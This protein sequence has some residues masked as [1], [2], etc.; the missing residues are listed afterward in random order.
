MGDSTTLRVK[1]QLM[2]ALQ[3]SLPDGAIRTLGQIGIETDH[4]TGQLKINEDALSQALEQ[5]THGVSRLLAGE[6]GL[7]AQVTQAIDPFQIGRAS[8]RG[9]GDASA[10]SRGGRATAQRR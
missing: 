1:N 7:G 10:W 3:F 2:T 8:C 6:N 4:T 5:D 9:R